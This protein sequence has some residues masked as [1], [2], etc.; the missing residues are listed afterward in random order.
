MSPPSPPPHR[1]CARRRVPRNGSVKLPSSASP[2]ESVTA[3]TAFAFNFA[4]P[5]SPST[6]HAR[7]ILVYKLPRLASSKADNRSLFPTHSVLCAFALARPFDANPAC[8][9]VT[10]LSG[11]AFSVSRERGLCSLLTLFR[12]HKRERELTTYTTGFTLSQR[13]QLLLRPLSL[14]TEYCCADLPV[15]LTLT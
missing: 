12:T 8:R 5:F 10:R 13:G 2:R 14:H 6:Q 7:R 1:L 11:S 15:S 3:R 4:L 9:A